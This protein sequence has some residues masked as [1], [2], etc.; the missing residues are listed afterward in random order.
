MSLLDR[1]RT[2][3]GA[4]PREDLSWGPREHEVAAVLE[5]LRPAFQADGGDLELRAITADGR[6]LL[7]AKGACNGCG[8]SALTLQ[9]VVAPA[10]R[11]T[12]PW[13]TGLELT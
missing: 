1:L 11:E 13:M 6:V 8:A 7:E 12:C 4:G 9:G 3:F 10:L 5:R 2:L